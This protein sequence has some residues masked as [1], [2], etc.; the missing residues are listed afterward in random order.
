LREDDLTDIIVVAANSKKAADEAIVQDS[1]LIEGPEKPVERVPII[2]LEYEV[3]P[4]EKGDKL[5]EAILI[6]PISDGDD[7][8]DIVLS[9]KPLAKEQVYDC[10][11]GDAECKEAFEAYDLYEVE[12]DNPSLPED[13]KL[14]KSNNEDVMADGIP[15]I[16]K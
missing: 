2:E 5:E 7:F 8:Y 15:A 16:M 3:D 6:K 4:F 10:K 12:I 14:L 11:E 13:F 1:D 9:D